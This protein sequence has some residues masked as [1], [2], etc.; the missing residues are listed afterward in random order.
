L[1]ILPL[2]TTSEFAQLVKDNDEAALLILL[3]YYALVLRLLSDR[4]WW[5]RDRSAHVCKSI[6]T[7]LGNK[8]ER[9]LGCVRELCAGGPILLANLI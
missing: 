7:N 5:M 8:C 9:C 1:F 2:F 3:H 6:L 4:Y